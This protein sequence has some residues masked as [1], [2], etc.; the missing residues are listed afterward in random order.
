M[1]NLSK[2]GE[3]AFDLPVVEVGLTLRLRNALN[4]R[5]ADLWT[6]ILEPDEGR[7]CMVWG[8]CFSVGKQ[9]SQ[10]YSVEVAAGGPMAN[11]LAEGSGA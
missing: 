2:D 10:A 8:A 3:I 4:R 6:V 9:P 7:C 11:E 5:K 1:V